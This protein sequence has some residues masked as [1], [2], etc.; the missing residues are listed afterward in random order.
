MAATA[1]MKV[2]IDVDRDELCAA[3]AEGADAL[4]VIAIESAMFASRCRES[5]DAN[6]AAFTERS[7]RLRECVRTLSRISDQLR[8]QQ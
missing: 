5:R 1:D 6:A 7:R 2:T 8:P 4:L 3:L